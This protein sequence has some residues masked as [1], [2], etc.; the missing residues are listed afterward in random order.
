[1]RMVVGKACDIMMYDSQ[2]IYK[3]ERFNFFLGRPPS[4]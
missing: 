4:D 1:M 3:L 2:Y